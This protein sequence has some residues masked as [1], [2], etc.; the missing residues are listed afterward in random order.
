[1]TQ[2]DIRLSKQNRFCRSA[3]F[4]MCKFI[5]YYK[6]MMLQNSNSGNQIQI[7]LNWIHQT[8]AFTNMVKSNISYYEVMERYSNNRSETQKW[9]GVI[10]PVQKKKNVVSRN[11]Y[12]MIHK[13]RQKMLYV[14]HTHLCVFNTVKKIDSIH[15]TNSFQC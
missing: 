13:M 12:C 7:S 6:I 14:A 4:S 10:W 5:L 11:L 1:M 2:R 9:L 15:S 3:I 8:I